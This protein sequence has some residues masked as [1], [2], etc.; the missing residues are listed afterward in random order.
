MT[1]FENKTL[2]RIF[3]SKM[4]AIRDGGMEGEREED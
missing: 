2:K 1:L 3:K 4:E